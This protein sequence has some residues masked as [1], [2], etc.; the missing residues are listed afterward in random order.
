MRPS[1]ALTNALL[2]LDRAVG[3]EAGEA[4]DLAAIEERAP[5][6]E[7]RRV[8]P[9]AH[10]AHPAEREELPYLQQRVARGLRRL[11]QRRAAAEPPRRVGSRGVAPTRAPSRAAYEQQWLGRQ[12][13]G[14]AQRA[15]A[16]ADRAGGAGAALL[17]DSDSG[18]AAGA[19]CS[20][21]SRSS[22]RGVNKHAGGGM[23]EAGRSSRMWIW[24]GALLLVLGLL[25]HLF[26]AQAIG[27]SRLAYT[28]HVFGFFVG[29]VVFGGVAGRWGG[30]TGNIVRTLRGS[31]ESTGGSLPASLVR[32]AR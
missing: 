7:L 16:G 5:P 14:A 6:E 20:C 32:T 4:R 24:F 3:R 2:A 30:A 19:A 1:R 8:Q 15:I 12:A 22:R 31:L 9:R 29:L 26:A 23:S 18:V 11:Q 17:A 10:F 25:G 13:P 28:H 21:H 27:G